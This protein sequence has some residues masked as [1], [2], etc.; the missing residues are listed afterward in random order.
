MQG[1]DSGTFLSTEIFIGSPGIP[2]GCVG[3]G[4][5]IDTNSGDNGWGL[6]TV[7]KLERFEGR[8]GDL[9]DKYARHGVV[10]RGGGLA[11]DE[12]VWARHGIE[13]EVRF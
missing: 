13:A 11:G 10:G 6:L 8:I 1:G 9:V 12:D 5:I 3:R 4:W 2:N 7:G